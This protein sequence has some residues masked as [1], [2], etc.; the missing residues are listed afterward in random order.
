MGNVA[1]FLAIVGVVCSC[2]CGGASAAFA[3]GTEGF[4]PAGIRLA[5]SAVIAEMA[6]YFSG[7]ATETTV[8]WSEV[9]ELDGS[10][11]PKD[12]VEEYK[13]N[14]VAADD[15]YAGKRVAVSGRVLKIR[16]DIVDDVYVV[17]GAGD[18]PADWIQAYL[19]NE[20]AEGAGA[21]RKGQDVDLVC[22][23]KGM[24]LGHVVL[25]ECDEQGAYMERVKEQVTADV[26]A[27]FAGEPI[28]NNQ[29]EELRALVFYGYLAGARDAKNVCSPGPGANADA[30]RKLFAAVYDDIRNDKL[31]EKELAVAAKL[32][33]DAE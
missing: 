13:E 26:D 24:L 4:S 12:M 20:A 9:A 5:K 18:G 10:I 28:S 6:A 33:V 8:D 1:R 29:E 15:A 22:T 21:L 2:C 3:Q 17:I 11:S 14:E 23:V 27:V 7:E 30:C 32:G 25:T 16:K 31:S 19:V